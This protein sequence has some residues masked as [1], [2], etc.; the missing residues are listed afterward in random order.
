MLNSYSLPSFPNH[1]HPLSSQVDEYLHNLISSICLLFS[2]TK[3]VNPFCVYFLKLALAQ[4]QATITLLSEYSGL[5]SS[6]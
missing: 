1:K 6:G 5:W 3:I 2:L 4:P